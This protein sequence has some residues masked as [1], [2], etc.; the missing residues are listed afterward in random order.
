MDTTPFWFFI[1]FALALIL[2]IGCV[3]NLIVGTPDN[4]AIWRFVRWLVL[5][6]G[7]VLRQFTRL[8]LNFLTKITLTPLNSVYIWYKKLPQLLLDLPEKYVEKAEQDARNER[9]KEALSGY[10][11]ALKMQRIVRLFI[12]RVP[13]ETALA[14]KA[15]NWLKQIAHIS[16][17]AH[18][19]FDQAASYYEM[20][21]ALLLK[22]P[23]TPT[24]I[25][26]I[27][28]LHIEGGKKLYTLYTQS[29]NA[30]G[31]AVGKL[32]NLALK[33]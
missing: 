33:H 8:L 6:L 25:S 12:K 31:K 22:Q 4:C 26:S 7:T 27:V 32:L 3:I 29:E 16:V 21:L 19:Q 20:A 28:R 17:V 13:D 9:F 18:Q 2:M 10:E 11:K 14:L 1:L 15:A 5:I 30:E 23:Q 24:V